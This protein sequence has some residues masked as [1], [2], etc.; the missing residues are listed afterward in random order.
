MQLDRQ[1]DRDSV[2]IFIL[3][4]QNKE[5]HTDN[6]IIQK[7]ISIDKMYKKKFKFWGAKKNCFSKL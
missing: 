7:N 6:L 5:G 1:R 3:D 4:I 2:D